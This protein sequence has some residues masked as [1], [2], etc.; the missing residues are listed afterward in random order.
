MRFGELVAVVA[1]ARGID[2]N[3]VPAS[4]VEALARLVAER[5]RS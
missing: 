3:G 5:I 4:A 1:S 2:G